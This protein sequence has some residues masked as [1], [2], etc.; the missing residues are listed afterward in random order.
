MTIVV[1]GHDMTPDGCHGIFFAGDSGISDGD[2]LL[3]AGFKKVFRY[4]IVVKRPLIVG[5]QFRGYAGVA[6]EGACAIAFAGSTLVAQQFM[7]SIGNHLSSLYA[8]HEGNSYC[9]AMPCEGGRLLNARPGYYQYEDEMFDG[10]FVTE[11][12]LINGEFIAGVVQHALEEVFKY[13]TQYA[14]MQDLFRRQRAEFILAMRCYRTSSYRLFKFEILE[15][16]D[17]SPIVQTREILRGMLA[18][19]GMEDEF[20]SDVQQA[21]NKAI[22]SGVLPG[23][24]VAEILAEKVQDK[25]NL[26]IFKVCG[27]CILSV[28]DG[29]ELTAV[30]RIRL[31]IPDAAKGRPAR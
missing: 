18:V 10:C 11:R 7:N 24:A 2:K 20:G 14:G 23:S 17:G 16:D 12:Q 1:A 22:D 26:G 3:V 27:P 6:F 8:T 4:P 29:V 15:S 25:N 13:A 5:S 31:Q 19:I 9:L 30:K 21:Y 28:Y